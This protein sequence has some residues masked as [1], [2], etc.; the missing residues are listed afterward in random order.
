ML[1]IRFKKGFRG[2][3]SPSASIHSSMEG[4]FPMSAYTKLLGLLLL[5]ASPVLFMGCGTGSPVPAG[6]SASSEAADAAGGV[7][8]AAAPD[9]GAPNKAAGETK[10]E[11]SKDKETTD[12]EATDKE[13]PTEEKGK[14]E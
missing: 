14:T 8:K 4:Q 12:K 2:S 7:N 3:R 9:A 1:A 10:E 5:S 6:S 13:K 11:D